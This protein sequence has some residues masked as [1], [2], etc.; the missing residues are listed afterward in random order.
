MV[1]GLSSQ[2]YSNGKYWCCG[3]LR[4][5]PAWLDRYKIDTLHSTSKKDEEF[6]NRGFA[7]G[8][9][10]KFVGSYLALLIVSVLSALDKLFE[11]S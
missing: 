4:F 10:I 11:N 3:L 6:G 1:Y 9:K 7:G 5:V 2:G 8:W